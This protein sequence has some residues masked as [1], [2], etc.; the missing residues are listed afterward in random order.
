MHDLSPQRE[1]FAQGVAAGKSQSDA[2]REAYPRSLAW[3][4]EVLHSKASVLAAD[5]RVQARVESLRAEITKE[6]VYDMAAAFVELEEAIGVAKSQGQAGAYVSAVQL[7][8][9]MA[10]LLIERKEVKVDLLSGLSPTALKQ[11]E[12]T[13]SLMVTVPT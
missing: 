2:Y 1:R 10:G 7:K 4:P 3:K 6:I 11:L 12:V 8:A 5:G 9:R 13:L